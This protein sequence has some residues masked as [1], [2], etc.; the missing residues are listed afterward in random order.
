M[1]LVN[2]LLSL[3]FTV[4]ICAQEQIT[5]TQNIQYDDHRSCI[6]DVAQP[7][8]NS[9]DLRPAIVIIHGGGWS[10]GD[11]RDAVYTNL[12]VDYA[13]KGYVTF[14]VNYRLTQE[15]EMPACIED[16]E[17]SISWIKAH[18]LEYGVDATRIGSFGH[19]AGGHLSLMLGV[20]GL[21]TCAVGGA[22][23]TEIG[24]PNIPWSQHTEWWPIGYI[25][26]ETSP[27]LI[28]QGSEDPIVR[29]NLTEDFVQ[30]MHKV[31]NKVEF[32]KA[33]G[34][35]GFAYDQ[36]LEITRPAMD[37]FFA[38]H[39]KHDEPRLSWEQ[40]KVLDGGGSGRYR[41]VAL[42]EK[43]LTDFV[44]YRPLDIKN[45]VRHEGKLPILLFANGG[46]MDTSVGY[47]RMLT[48]IA[49]HG[50]VVVA[51]G[52]M[53][54]YQFDREEKHTQSSMLMDAM[55]WI[56]KAS[57]TEGSNYCGMVDTENIAAAGHSCGGAQVLCNANQPNLKTY[58]ILNAGMGK[59]EMAGASAR[60]LKELHAPI[61][62]MTGGEGDVAYRNAEMDYNSIHN[63]HA[64]WADNTKAG[65][66]GTYNQPMG[67]SFARMVVDWLDW[68]LKGNT[69]NAANFIKTNDT[70]REWTI[71]S[72]GKG[73]CHEL[74]I[75][76]KNGKSIYGV[77]S[78]PNTHPGEGKGK[79]HGVAI[80]SHGFNG[81][82]HFGKD[83]FKTLNNLGYAVYTF[84]YPCGSI[85][86]QSDNNT[87]EMSITDEKNA[88]K[89]IVA[90]FQKQ[91]DVDRNRIV[92]IGESQGGLVSALAASELKKQISNLVLIYP[93]LC[94]PDNWN[95]RYPNIDD[96]P[97]VS[98]IWGVKLG[99]KFMMDIRPMKPFET[100]GKYKGNVLIVHGT[101][102]KVVPL[103]YS[104][105]AVQTYQNA[106]LKIINKAGHGFNPQ[107]RNLSNQ[108][109]R[110]FLNLNDN[111][112]R[113]TD[114]ENG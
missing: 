73:L 4:S 91:K 23:P 30:K 2:I 36:G 112:Q 70:Y 97:E 18:A 34:Q 103:D 109:V 10:A 32:I 16:V 111:R 100:I 64:V 6:L 105:R 26:K 90:Y 14:S 28:L 107:E 50:Y 12:L 59:M 60:N 17:R 57:S 92:L 110:E 38:R 87:M 48:E 39:L 96:I 41:A 94:I 20:K 42:K 83:Y 71:Q 78:N 45:A 65:H 76:Q 37:A 21:V 63:V 85:H 40:M 68:H 31:G 89:E 95:A 24:N 74:R 22:P 113:T 84:D 79:G 33:R 19:S 82:H 11:K 56:I 51:I 67:G 44:V 81:T 93:A 102:D 29:P 80:I 9:K 99:K 62:Y 27:M 53:Q 25:Q 108:Y 114:N 61:I 5:V 86:S 49:S 3:L 47:E 58:I 52:E 54:V 7:V 106:T 101:D 66:G 8:S 72:N 77:I 1:K 104:E 43:S 15:A 98:E 55:N 88:L 69:G 75:P 35:H 46:C 13:M